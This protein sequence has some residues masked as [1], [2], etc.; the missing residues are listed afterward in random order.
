VALAAKR[1]LA[2]AGASELVD[3]IAAY[4]A[5]YL[6]GDRRE[7]EARLRALYDP[8]LAYAARL[9]GS[10]N[11]V[12]IG[13]LGRTIFDNFEPG[14]FFVVLATAVVLLLAANTAFHG[15]PAFGSVLARDGYLP[16]QLQVRGDRL[17]LSNGILLLAGLSTLLIVVFD[18][19]VHRLV[20]L[21]I[22]GV[23]VSF[24]VSQAG[25]V[26]HW[27]RLLRKSKDPSARRTMQW[28]R[29]INAVGLSVTG[30]VL[31]VVVVTMVVGGYG[32]LGERMIRRSLAWQM[33]AGVGYI[34]AGLAIGTQLG[35][36]AGLFYMSH[37]IIVMGSLLLASAAIEHA[38]RTHQFVGLSG[39][40]KREPLLAVIMALGMMSL[41][42]FPPS[43]GFFGKVGVVRA[44]AELDGFQ[45][46]MVLG[47][48]LVASIG[49]L[50][51]MVAIWREVF[52]GPPIEDMP[53]HGR[54]QPVP[55][56][57]PDG[58]RLRQHTLV[59]CGV[60]LAVSLLM[61]LFP[62]PIWELCLQAA[63]GLVDVTGYAEA[64]MPR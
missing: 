59:P 35:L 47:A 60:L 54:G 16:R 51:A 55:P 49:T 36:A 39:F 43:S 6:A 11:M 45:L 22:V 18:A 12:V 17:A 62:G 44:A 2:E 29:G 63:A 57:C 7:L 19:N 42:G 41:V 1:V 33:V 26:V 27:T 48:V 56:V 30:I 50:L 9:I 14:F 37:H 25:M 13:Q 23:F 15:F 46:W 21:Y 32:S 52:W 38:Y 40:M 4:R 28:S 10:P 24:T 61:F 5:G 64:V 58:T 34:L 53:S 8:F 20:Q 3:R 31:V